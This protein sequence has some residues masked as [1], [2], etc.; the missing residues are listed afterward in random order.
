MDEIFFFFLRNLYSWEWYGI[1]VRSIGFG[2]K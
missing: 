2:V 1:V